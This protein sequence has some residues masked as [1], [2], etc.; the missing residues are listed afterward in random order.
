[1]DAEGYR[2]RQTARLEEIA[3]DAA[4]RVIESGEAVALEP[5]NARDRRTVHM[6]IAEIEGAASYSVGEEP[7]P[8]PRD[9]PPR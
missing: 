3:R 1:M 4:A 7:Y 9:L 5:M 6:V 8:P 2:Q